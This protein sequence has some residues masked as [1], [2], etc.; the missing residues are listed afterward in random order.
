ML[1]KLQEG[2]DPQCDKHHLALTGIHRKQPLSQPQLHA[3]A[4]LR[5]AGLCNHAVTTAMAGQTEQPATNTRAR[6]FGH[7]ALPEQAQEHCDSEQHAESLRQPVPAQTLP[8]APPQPHCPDQPQAQLRA[9]P[10][11]L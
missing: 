4:G 3:Q 2:C 11:Q 7:S 6:W 5:E 1:C 10:A 8:K 9:T